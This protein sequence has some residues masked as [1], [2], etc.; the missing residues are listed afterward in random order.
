MGISGKDA[1]PTVYHAADGAHVHVHRPG[2]LLRNLDGHN[3]Y[4]C[5]PDGQP[6]KPEETVETLLRLALTDSLCVRYEQ[7][8]VADKQE[9]VCT[10][11]QYLVTNMASHT[12]L[13][14]FDPILVWVEMKFNAPVRVSTRFLGEPQLDA[15][16][17]GVQR[18]LEGVPLISTRHPMESDRIYSHLFP[19]ER[20]NVLYALQRIA[21][22]L[23]GTDHQSTL[24]HSSPRP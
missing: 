13:Q 4:A 15:L 18:Y 9:E 16:M 11:E 6:R 5:G 8:P 7:G 22:L 12:P 3:Q 2:A 14:V 17:H 23:L 1:H 10:M 24:M 19:S 21:V 20:I